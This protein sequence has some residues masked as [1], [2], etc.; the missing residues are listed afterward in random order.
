MLLL[1]ATNPRFKRPNLIV[2]LRTQMPAGSSGRQRIDSPRHG[3]SS[4]R[5][6]QDVSKKASVIFVGASLSNVIR[7][8]GDAKSY[9]KRL[10]DC[11]TSA[12]SNRKRTDEPSKKLKTAFFGAILQCAPLELEPS[13]SLGHYY[14]LPY[15]KTCQL[16][17][18]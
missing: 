3:R 8:V 1:D 7:L 10:F 15:G 2:N 6:A 5:H 14:L 12:L 13:G 17:I 18:D 4:R 11:G 9:S 16:I